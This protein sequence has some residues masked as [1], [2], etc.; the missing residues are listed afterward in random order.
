[1]ENRWEF[2]MVIYFVFFWYDLG[3][4]RF[5][6]REVKV[7]VRVENLNEFGMCGRFVRFKIEKNYR[8]KKRVIEL[9]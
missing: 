5:V 9:G 1:M 3:G 2:L 8:R 4:E 6:I 7:E